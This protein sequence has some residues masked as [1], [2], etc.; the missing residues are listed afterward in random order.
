M[1]FSISVVSAQQAPTASDQSWPKKVKLLR[2]TQLEVRLGTTTASRKVPRN[3]EVEVVQVDLPNLQI[4][5]NTAT[6]TVPAAI[7]DFFESPEYLVF[8][9]KEAKRLKSENEIA[10]AKE[11]RSSTGKKINMNTA[12]LSELISLPRIG[13]KTAAAIIKFRPFSK[14]EDLDRIPNIGP[15][16]IKQ[17]K[18]LIV[19]ETAES[20]S[21]P[22]RSEQATEQATEQVTAQV[23]A[24]TTAQT[25]AQAAE[26]PREKVTKQQAPTPRTDS[27]PVKIT[28]P[29]TGNDAGGISILGSKAPPLSPSSWV[30]GEPMEN[31]EKGKVYLLDC[32][33]LACGPCIRSIPELRKLHEKYSDKGLVVVGVGKDGDEA[34][35]KFLK[36][37]KGH[38]VTYRIIGGPGYSGRGSS[39]T[40]IDRL[41]STYGTIAYPTVF[42]VR[43]GILLWKGRPGALKDEDIQSMLAGTF[44][45]KK[46]VARR[47]EAENAASIGKLAPTCDSGTWV[48]GEPINSYEKS[49]LYLISFGDPREQLSVEA[50]PC[51]QKLHE[52]YSSKGLVVIGAINAL[53]N[54]TRDLIETYGTSM[55]YPVLATQI[56]TQHDGW[57]SIGS[58]LRSEF[59]RACFEFQALRAFAI[60]DG[61]VV[62]QGHPADLKDDMIKKMLAGKTPSYALTSI[63]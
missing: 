56:V 52:T 29:P 50:F 49:K 20:P 17:L 16:T 19:T 10:A 5:Q 33:N 32:W 8:Q 22:I 63:P 43:D 37:E 3:T 18:D 15:A 9:Q 13:N 46:E 7:T 4:R 61:K 54:E 57:R 45:I 24:Q 48:Q 31:Y 41:K 11:A 51:L 59:M 36:T 21:P 42:M 14:L 53:E 62:W 1:A 12:S 39:N 35:A 2:E 27:P 30:Q 26:K 55:S 47:L 40:L 58:K 25:T 60:Y 38:D 28:P 44:D 34:I 23:T 6:A